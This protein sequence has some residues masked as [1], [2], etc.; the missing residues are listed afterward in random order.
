MSQ[1]VFHCVKHVLYTSILLMFCLIL[2]NKK[3]CIY[4]IY[5]CV[6]YL[7]DKSLETISKASLCRPSSQLITDTQ[8][9]WQRWNGL[10]CSA[11]FWGKVIFL[12]CFTSGTH[13]INRLNLRLM[14]NVRRDKSQPKPKN[15]GLEIR[16]KYVS[17]TVYNAWAALLQ[18]TDLSAQ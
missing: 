18:G 12:E 9:Q 17:H 13:S 5:S 14:V 6:Y 3:R 4:I 10:D 7:V 1:S 2:Q 16:Y 11:V 15:S 8:L